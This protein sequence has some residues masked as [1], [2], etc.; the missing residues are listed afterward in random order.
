MRRARMRIGVA[1]GIESVSALQ[2]FRHSMVVRIFGE[3]IVYE[4]TK[5]YIQRQTYLFLP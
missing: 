3:S 2:L 5:L 1:D 4:N